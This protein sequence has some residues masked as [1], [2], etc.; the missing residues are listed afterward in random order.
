MPKLF[1]KKFFGKKKS[2]E[3][4]ILLEGGG[5]GGI[6]VD[7]GDDTNNNNDNNYLDEEAMAREEAKERQDA[8]RQQVASQRPTSPPP[9][10][11]NETH[12]QQ[13]FV[14][15]GWPKMRYDTVKTVY[16]YP[17]KAIQEQ[18][19]YGRH[20][21]YCNETFVHNDAA[22]SRAPVLL[23][24]C[25]HINCSACIIN[26]SRPILLN[27][28]PKFAKAHPYILASMSYPRMECP[29]CDCPFTWESVYYFY[30]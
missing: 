22:S 15:D 27:R 13:C 18:V 30:H 6:V 5:D 14:P 23:V 28:C 4:Q 11:P 9:E 1:G 29:Q 19:G 3:E 16:Q 7:E 12:F 2:D 21:G 24:T 10:Q 26:N 8:Q 25:R 20:C 17:S